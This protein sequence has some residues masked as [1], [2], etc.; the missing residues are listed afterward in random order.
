MTVPTTDDSIDSLLELDYEIATIENLDKAK[1]F[2]EFLRNEEKEQSK[3]IEKCTSPSKR[4]EL[5]K[6]IFKKKEDYISLFAMNQTH[7]FVSKIQNILE[8]YDF[9]MMK[10]SVGISQLDLNA[11][12]EEAV[13]KA[14]NDLLSLP[15]L[16]DQYYCSCLTIKLRNAIAR[17]QHHHFEKNHAKLLEKEL[18]KVLTEYDCTMTKHSVGTSQQRLNAIHQDAIEK[19][20]NKLLA[21]PALANDSDLRKFTQKQLKCSI[22]RLQQHHFQKN[23]LLFIN[24]CGGEAAKKRYCDPSS[25][26]IDV[27]KRGILG[28]GGF[29]TVRMGFLE[30]YGTVAV[31][32]NRYSG[33]NLEITNAEQKCIK[34][35]SLLHHANHE[36]ILRFLGYSFGSESMAIITEY[37]PGGSLS[38]LLFC[39]NETGEFL[40]PK[41]SQDL[42]LRFCYD[43]SN[44]VS[45][46]HFAFFD[47][48]VVHG[49]LKPQNVLL[50]S[51]LRCKVGD[52]GGA[53]VATCTELLDSAQRT[54]CVGEWTQGYIA[55]ERLSNPRLRVTKAMDVYSVGMIFYVILRRQHPSRD[56][57]RNKEE[58]TRYCQQR[59]IHIELK[60]LILK[61]VDHV[62]QK[63]PKMLEVRDALQDLL[64]KRDAAEIARNVAAVLKT[65]KCKTFVDNISD[66]VSLANV[67]HF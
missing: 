49:D 51:D 43:I 57:F 39:K 48:R 32:F 9:T 5:K 11:I 67:F 44:G 20:E 42:C 37:M 54:G 24:H 30:H 17:L 45:Y 60:Q 38:A 59:I 13:E 65:Y 23:R 26:K 22:A 8:N 1:N 14:K 66:F 52:F 19:A 28:R 64:S 58:I 40:V 61:C 41:I 18:Q 27:A 12:H 16:I 21:L 63:R 50:T 2:N 7:L 55:P 34:E 10:H 47:Q 35:I 25:I 4:D 15:N 3:A 46:L 6:R 53:D 29:S 36:N 31:K 62:Y 33:S 56:V